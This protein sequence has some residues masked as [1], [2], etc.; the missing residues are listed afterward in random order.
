[1]SDSATEPDVHALGMAVLKEQSL[2][3]AV[4]GGVIGAFIAVAI[5][6]AAAMATNS[7][8][9]VMVILV[10]LMVGAFVR[11]NGRGIDGWYR[12]IA[13]LITIGGSVAGV[14]LTGLHGVN[15]IIAV[16]ALVF[17]AA[18]ACRR[19]RREQ[20]ESVWKVRHNIK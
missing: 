13:A 10:G 14:L 16:I 8:S 15:P 12:L 1:M 18:L 17:S 11:F 4:A 3:K 20:A 7:T 2:I 5:W 19:L 6:M 9:D